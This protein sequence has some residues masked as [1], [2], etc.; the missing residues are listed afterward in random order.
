MRHPSQGPGDIVEDGAQSQRIRGRVE[1]CQ[2]PSS[3]FSL[4][5]AVAML[6]HISCGY[7]HKTWICMCVLACVHTHISTNKHGLEIGKQGT[8]GKIGFI[9]VGWGSGR[10]QWG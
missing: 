7:R 3:G 2:M 10:R 8:V 1:C 4:A 9:G 6:P 5:M